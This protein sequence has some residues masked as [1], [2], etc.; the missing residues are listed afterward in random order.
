MQFNIEVVERSDPKEAKNNR[1][2]VYNKIDVIYKKDGKVEAK[3]LADFANK[4]I[5]DDLLA[6]Q[7]GD[8]K[9]VTVEKNANGYWEWKSVGEASAEEQKPTQAASNTD[10]A[11]KKGTGKVL[12]SNYETPDE[13]AKRQ[14][15]I[16]RQSSISNAIAFAELNKLTKSHID[17]VIANA[18]TFEAYVL[19]E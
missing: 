13:R 2:G 18:K 10:A 12:G 8:V 4:E 6:L 14:V 7:K 16:V 19:G 3:S 9:T 17:D 15:M 5:W 11:A 1:G